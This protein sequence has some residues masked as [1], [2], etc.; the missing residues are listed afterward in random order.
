VVEVGGVTL[1]LLVIVT[2]L[3]PFDGG[4]PPVSRAKAAADPGWTSWRG[5]DIVM[6]LIELYTCP[7]IFG[8]GEWRFL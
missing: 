5:H 8:V 2:G 1:V 6:D 7:R 3:A 4:R